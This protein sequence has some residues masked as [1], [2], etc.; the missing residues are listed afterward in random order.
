MAALYNKF[1]AAYHVPAVSIWE[2]IK[3]LASVQ[4]ICFALSS[5]Q[6]EPSVPK[7]VSSKSILSCCQ[8]KND[9]KSVFDLVFHADVLQAIKV[10]LFRM[11]RNI[12]LNQ[13]ELFSAYLPFRHRFL[14]CTSPNLGMI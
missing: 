5:L 7:L 10:L 8:M 13:S 12:Y 3:P 6:R 4:E 11:P 2:V 9:L 14:S 1:E